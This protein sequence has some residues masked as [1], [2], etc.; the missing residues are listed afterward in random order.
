M[1]AVSKQNSEG[2]KMR[3]WQFFMLLSAIVTAPY[4]KE[5]TAEFF[6]VF[7]LFIAIVC[8]FVDRK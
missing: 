1:R 4:L 2:K 3:D 7:Y 5:S 8:M 6:G